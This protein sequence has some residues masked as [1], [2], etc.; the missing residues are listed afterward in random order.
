[1]NGTQA[2]VRTHCD[3]CG[4]VLVIHER[5]PHNHQRFCSAACRVANWRAQRAMANARHDRGRGD[6]QEH[7][8]R[9]PAT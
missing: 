1:M 5:T 3:F 7:E 9:A 4:L 6:D 2:T 8:A